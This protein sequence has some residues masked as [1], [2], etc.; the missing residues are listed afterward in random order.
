MKK[1]NALIHETSPYLLQHAYNPVDWQPWCKEAIQKAQRED[2]PILISI[3]YSAC[4]WCHVMERESFEDEKVAAFMN[5]HFVCI[6]VDREERPDLDHIYMEAVQ[7]LTGQGGW[8]LNVFLTPDGKPFYGGTYYPPFPA[9]GRP[10]WFQVLQS[11]AHSFKNNR[12]AIN[13]YAQKLTDFIQKKTKQ[14][15]SANVISFE[16]ASHQDFKNSLEKHLQQCRQ[17]FDTQYGGF[18]DAPK[19][20]HFHNLLFLLKYACHT[21]DSEIARH[22]FF[23]LDAMISGGIYDQIG[24]GIARY[25]T[26]ALWKVP[27]FEKMLYDNALLI[28][29]LA[30]CYAISRNERYREALLQTFDFLER[31]MLSAEGGFYAAL[32]ADSEGVEGKFY[33]WTKNE[34]EHILGEDALWYCELFDIS[35]EGNWEHVNILNQSFSYEAFAKRQHWD[36]ELLKNKIKSCNQKLLNERN[37]RKRPDTDDKII[38]GWNALMCAALAKAFEFTQ[39]E[40][41]RA[42]ALRNID[43]LIKKFIICKDNEIIVFHTYKNNQAKQPA[44]LDDVALLIHALIAC[45]RIAFNKSYLLLARQLCDYVIAHFFDKNE[46]AFYYTSVHQDDIVVRATELFDSVTPS[47]N[48]V[49]AQNLA[50]LAT[51][52]NN[53]TYHQISDGMLQKIMHSVA[54]YPLSFGNWSILMLQKVF[55]VKE[56]IIVGSEHETFARIIMQQYIPASVLLSTESADPDIALLAGKSVT[57]NKTLVYLCENNVCRSVSDSVESF[58]KQCI[59]K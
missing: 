16:T 9:H 14:F 38:L 58:L 52:F 11:V 29:T 36:V 18:G 2:K 44:F 6:K 43:F 12:P 48:S 20:P 33:V 15:L 47:G 3:G 32:D 26:D 27:H 19:F 31:E 37:K 25:S 39:H 28:E 54:Q 24:G 51:V 10:S 22:V 45:C 35:E 8:P 46:G 55:P 5:Q 30:E 42:L 17:Y 57:D 1:P 49:M 53:S 21:Q 59:T 34:I 40:P 50:T 4:H 41:I 23:S 56:I 13:E 7:V